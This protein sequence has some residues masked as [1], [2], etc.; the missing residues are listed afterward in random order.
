[1]QK[2]ANLV[3]IEKCCQTHILLQNFVLIQPRTSPPKICKIFEKC[4]FE[5][6][7]FRKCIFASSLPAVGRVANLRE[8]ARDVNGALAVDGVLDVQLR[9]GLGGDGLPCSLADEDEVRGGIVIGA[10]IVEG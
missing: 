3:E 6:C 7:I 10:R 8:P 9:P 1:M 4:I 2:Y 5:K